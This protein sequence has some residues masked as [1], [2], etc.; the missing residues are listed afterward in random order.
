VAAR[1][2]KAYY[3]ETYFGQNSKINLGSIT[4]YAENRAV[5]EITWENIV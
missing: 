1:G 5:Y 2:H 3:N 4:F